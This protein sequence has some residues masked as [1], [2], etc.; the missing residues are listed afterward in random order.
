[1][2]K[3]YFLDIL[4]DIEQEFENDINDMYYYGEQLSDRDIDLMLYAI[5]CY[6]DKVES[7]LKEKVQ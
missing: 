2:K 4:H 7:I 5:T 3:D 6:K 1:M